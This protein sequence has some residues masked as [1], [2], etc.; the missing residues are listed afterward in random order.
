MAKKYSGRGLKTITIAGPGI[1]TQ[2]FKICVGN[3][4]EDVKKWIEEM[5]ICSGVVV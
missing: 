5:V 1:P 4:P 3:H 2:K